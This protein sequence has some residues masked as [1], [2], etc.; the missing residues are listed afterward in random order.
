MTLLID[1]PARA[2]SSP[3]T[4][5]IPRARLSLLV[6]TLLATTFCWWA[7]G[8]GY[9]HAIKRRIFPAAATAAAPV[10]HAPRIV[11]SQPPDGATD[12]PL[13]TVVTADIASTAGLE[14][15][16]LT[17]GTVLLVRTSDQT[18]VPSTAHFS[19]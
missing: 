8:R 7:R 3:R 1:T 15:T 14:R 4:R 6:L 2:T 16:S 10:A 11:V 17:A 12:V 9:V 13:D 19:S 5:A 18:V